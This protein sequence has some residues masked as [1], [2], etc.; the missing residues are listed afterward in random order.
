MHIKWLFLAGPCWQQPW[1][2]RAAGQ[3]SG[4]TLGERLE[5]NVPF[6]PSLFPSAKFVFLFLAVLQRVMNVGDLPSDKWHALAACLE[7]IFPLC[8]ESSISFQ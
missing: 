7:T 8:D 5:G 1:V 3:I 4:A 6:P 2:Q